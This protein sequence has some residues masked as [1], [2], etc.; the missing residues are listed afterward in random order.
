MAGFLAVL[1]GAMSGLGSGMVENARA[2]REAAIEAMKM[3][4]ED[5]RAKEEREF[6][7]GESAKERTARSEEAE[8]QRDFDAGQTDKRFALE[9]EGWANQEKRDAI[10]RDFRSGEAGKDRDFRSGEGEKDR[11]SRRAEAEADRAWRSGEAEAQRTFDAHQTRAKIDFEREG[12]GNLITLSDGTTWVQVGD[13][14]RPLKTES[15]E[16]V[17]LKSDKW[18][19][20]T[21]DEAAALGLPADKSFQRGPDGEIKQIGSNGTTVNVGAG[22]K[23]W[24]TE[25]AKLF[26]KRYDDITGGAMNAEQMLGMYDLAEQALKSGVRTGVGAEAELTLRQFGAALGLDTDADKLA[27]GE[28]IRAIQNRMA[29]TMRSPDGGMGMPGALSDRDIK[30]LKDSQIGI[31]RS[32]EG[33][34]RMLQAFRA[35]EGRKIEIARLADQYIEQNG[36][37]DSGFNKMV[38]EFAESTP[39]FG[40][41]ADGR[42]ASGGRA[43]K[44]Q[45]SVEP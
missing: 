17:T 39:L 10:D 23:A 32:P 44:I 3:A 28:L 34:L 22:E 29:L 26:A 9:R 35:M 21:A 16:G 37:L 2:K 43:G 33:N 11:V 38:R 6:R 15:G 19:T 8:R 12:R 25:S 5:A 40:G 36:R 31:D 45:W 24:D 7:A 18:R 13:T 27:G 14:A 20:L 4:R 42:S 30:F 1:G 41:G